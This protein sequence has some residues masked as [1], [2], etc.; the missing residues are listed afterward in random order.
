V[1]PPSPVPLVIDT[2]PGIDDAL[3]VLLALASPEVDLRLVTTVHGNVELAQTTENALRVLH[4]ARRSDVPVAAGARGALVHPQ[5]ERAGHVHGTEGL[6]GVTL[7]PSPAAVDPRPAVVALA[8]LLESSPEPVTV[9]AIG[10][11]TNLALLLGVFPDAARRIGRLVVMGGSAARGGNV[12]AAAEFNAWADPEAAQAVLTAGLPTVLVPLDVTLPTVL[13]RPGIDRIA[14]AGEVGAAAA[15][16]LGRYVD[17]ARSRYGVDGVVV[18]DALA[19]TEAITPGT[20]GTVCR[21][22]V[23]DTTLGAGRGQTLVDR[24]SVSA[25]PTAVEVAETVDSDAAVEFLVGRLERYRG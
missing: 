4:L 5:A 2:D 22:V 6:G 9:A 3:A 15:R 7:A 10:P 14:A 11:L 19:L 21:D 20:L 16:I 18:H 23:V 24:R 12:T 17:N 8:E 25:A 1:A 13:T